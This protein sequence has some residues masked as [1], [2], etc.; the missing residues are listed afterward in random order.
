[1]DS[2]RSVATPVRPGRSRRNSGLSGS[3]MEAGF[4]AAGERQRPYM[5]TV[6]VEVLRRFGSTATAEA[7]YRARAGDYCHS[8]GAAPVARQTGVPAGAAA[9][10]LSSLSWTWRASRAEWS[11]RSAG[12]PGRRG[13]P[14]G[15]SP[16]SGRVR[17]HGWPAW[18]SGRPR[19]CRATTGGR[20]PTPLASSEDPCARARSGLRC[21]R[22]PVRPGADGGRRPL[23]SC[24][25][26][27]EGAVVPGGVRVLGTRHL[28]AAGW[29]MPCISLHVNSG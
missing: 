3:S 17:R 7:G 9:R 19:R 25:G 29:A 10:R 11:P 6:S 14:V 16:G 24:Q 2:N 13:C 8:G 4:R 18:M 28:V 23:I 22:R 15:W 20:N 26:R 21:A 5:L 1:M 27:S 12:H